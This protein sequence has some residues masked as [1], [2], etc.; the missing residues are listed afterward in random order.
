M[1]MGKNL[2]LFQTTFPGFAGRESGNPVSGCKIQHGMC[3]IQNRC[4]NYPSDI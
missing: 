1:W 2:E 4:V 3:R